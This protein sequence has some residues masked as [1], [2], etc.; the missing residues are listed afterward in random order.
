MT[1][2]ILSLTVISVISYSVFKAA[3]WAYRIQVRLLLP[4]D[5]VETVDS[6]INHTDMVIDTALANG[7]ELFMLIVALVRKQFAAEP[8]LAPAKPV[9]KP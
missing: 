6:A 1:P 9:A 5:I 7:K 2:F 4:S 3:V 8:S